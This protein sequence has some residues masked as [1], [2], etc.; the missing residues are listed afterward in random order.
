MVIITNL[1]IHP[2]KS[3]MFHETVLMCT[4]VSKK[5]YMKVPNK[6]H[7]VK[8]QVFCTFHGNGIL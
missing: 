4:N 8:H 7:V 3:M 5:V 1:L 6:Q 2:Q